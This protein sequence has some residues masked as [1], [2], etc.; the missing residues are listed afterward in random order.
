[1]GREAIWAAGQRVYE[2]EAEAI[3]AAGAAVCEEVFMAAGAAVCEEAFMAAVELLASAPR[4]AASGCGHSGIACQHFAHLMCC[5]ERPERFISP[6][7]AAHG[8]PAF[9]RKAT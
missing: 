7:E 2:I 6:V 5:I 3:T 8:A 1:M 9:S 4:I